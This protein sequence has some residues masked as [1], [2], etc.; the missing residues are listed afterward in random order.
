MIKITI[1]IEESMSDFDM[2][3]AHQVFG[4]LKDYPLR[5]EVEDVRNKLTIEHN[6]D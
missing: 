1:Y 3:K 6:I 5:M 2:S 4:L